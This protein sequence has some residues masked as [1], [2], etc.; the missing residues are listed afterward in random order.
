MAPKTDRILSYLPPTF[1]RR[2]NLSLS[3]LHAIVEAVGRQLTHGENSLVDVMRAHWVDYADR[4]AEEIED[5]Q[6]LAALYGLAPRPDESVEEFREHLKRYVRTFL[7]GTVTVQGILRVTAEVLGL[8]ILDAYDQLD[9]WWTR[10]TDTLLTLP[11]FQDQIE[12]QLFRRDDAT[13]LLLGLDLGFKSLAVSGFPDLPAQVQGSVDLSGTVDLRDGFML[14]LQVRDSDPVEINLIQEAEIDPQ[15]LELAD[16]VKAINEQLPADSHIVARKTEEN[17]LVLESSQVG[18]GSNLTVLDGENDAAERLLGLPPRTYWGSEDQPA[19]FISRQ[20][21]SRGVDL[22]DRDVIQLRI[23]GGVSVVVHCDGADP[24]N[25]RPAEIVNAINA[26]FEPWQVASHD[27]RFI[28][29]TA[30]ATG[31]ASEI[32]IE[33]PP[34][35]DATDLILGIP[36]RAFYGSNANQAEIVGRRDLGQSGNPTGQTE[37]V[38]LMARRFLSVAVDRGR[39]IEVDVQAGLLTARFDPAAATLQHVVEAINA[40]FPHSR[41]AYDDGHHLILRSPTVGSNSHIE[42]LP[43]MQTQC[44]R[45][46]SR[47]TVIDEAA[48]AVLGF[49]DRETRGQGAQPAQLGSPDTAGD[50]SP[51]DLS[52]GVDLQANAYLRLAIDN[53]PAIEIYCAGKRPRATTLDEIVTAINRATQ[54]AWGSEVASSYQGRH[55]VLTS[56]TADGESRLATQTHQTDLDGLD[57]LLGIATGTVNGQEAPDPNSDPL[58]AQVEGSR[59]LTGTI[60]LRTSR[61]LR[62]SVDDEPLVDVDCGSH[63]AD[64]ST[65]T[66]PNIVA[67]I[68]EALGE[69]KTA[70]G[71]P[72]LIASEDGTHL[73]LTSP[74]LGETSA[75]TLGTHSSGDARS[76]LL[77]SAPEI[78]EGQPATPAILEGEVNMLT[79]ADLSERSQLRLVVDDNPPVDI[80]IA[81]AAPATTFLDEVVEAI[82]Q[83][84]PNIASMTDTNHLKLTSPT[85][86]TASRIAVLPLRY[87]DLIEYVPRTT[88]QTVVDPS[89]QG[90]VSKNNPDAPDSQREN[91]NA[92]E[93]P[94]Y[95]WLID[96]MGA[97][98]SFAD[99][100]ITASRGTVGPTLVNLT[101]GHRIRL[102]RTLSTRSKAHVWRDEHGQLRA[103]VTSSTQE[104]QPVD[105][106]QIIVGPQGVQVWVPF[107]GQRSLR[108]GA[109]ASPTLQL[110]NPLAPQIV[111]LQ[112]R[113]TEGEITITV[114]EHVLSV[115]AGSSDGDNDSTRLVGRV[116]WH[117]DGFWQLVDDQETAIATLR[118]GLSISDAYRD[119]VVVV[120]G[121]YAQGEIIVQTIARLFD[122][123][124]EAAGQSAPREI[125]QGVTIGEAALTD[126]ALSRQINPGTNP[127]QLVTAELFNKAD[128][129]KLPLGRSEWLYKECFG[130]R[131]N[132]ANF[133]QAYFAG[134]SCR[135]VGIFN[136]SRFAKKPLNPM[137]EPPE[138]EFAAVFASV[139]AL[140]DKPTVK[141]DFVWPHYQPGTFQ[142]D[143]PGDLPPRFG[144]RFNQAR[145]SQAMVSQ[146]PA[147]EGSQLR[148]PDLT[149]LQ[150]EVYKNAVTEPPGDPNNLIKQIESSTLVT[151]SGVRKI[152]LGSTAVELPFRKPQFLVQGEP[153]RAAYL[154]LSEEGLSG[155]IKIEAKAPGSWGNDIAVSARPV[156][157]A[158]YDV[159]IFYAGGRFESA[160]RMVLGESLPTL[161]Q[162]LI[163]PGPIGLLQA[164]AAGIH[165][166]VSRD[167]AAPI[168]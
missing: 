53:Q 58:P 109:D 106:A 167:N 76:R 25:T 141:I 96:N 44:R 153:E 111:V 37:V 69:R 54:A 45:F 157:P 115:S 12:T 39:P 151:V 82:N 31:S 65:A 101:Q 135:S 125:Y 90:N 149:Q 133:D 71:E 83:V 21:L 92:T 10:G 15:A 32:V 9:T 160:R 107:T 8:R 124:L 16:I 1:R 84:Y 98:D 132:D 63:T 81:G 91:N 161:A 123:T 50:K 23:D 6:L 67:S 110:N 113:S 46:V 68:N 87:L 75:I 136:V 17:A 4:D 150:P 108:D 61:I 77:G 27:G 154:F 33:T 100:T 29:L 66:L 134:G 105:P 117:E 97:V 47:A 72:H 20:D 57:T 13:D 121:R 80:D 49:L 118:S 78:T 41:I 128:S 102:M 3:P 145:F 64:L 165:V 99:I 70:T 28:T 139:G 43:L 62:L 152:P 36:P 18:S 14:Y 35:G 138:N 163:K 143:L 51:P 19:Q 60:D 22:S 95:R 7:E 2:S 159:S 38:N 137:D 166:S 74:T 130:S 103:E 52:R 56:P 94:W 59:N 147:A 30:I 146:S 114:V 112:R 158:T 131:F 104:V 11:R 5:L 73:I 24:A 89:N 126:K 164:K 119:C 40:V 122:V 142:V 42:L 162:D 55:L 93:Q 86:G 85:Q 127:S 26:A 120:C 129:L 148:Y 79:P 116:R 88:A 156:G 144:G 155:F 168:D 140:G 48:Q 34:T